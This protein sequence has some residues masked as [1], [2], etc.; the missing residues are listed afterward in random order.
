M[1]IPNDTSPEA[2]AVLREVY[3]RMPFERKWQQMGV[4]Y[5]TARILHAAGVR[6]RHPEAT[7]ER[8]QEAWR[9]ETLGEAAV[10]EIGKPR[11][12]SDNENLLVVQEVIAVLSRLNILYAL[13]GSWASSLLGKPRLTHDA[14]LSAEPFPGKEADFCSAFGEEYYISLSAVRDAVRQRSSFNII[15]F[16]SGFKVDVFVRKD[17]AFDQSVMTRRQPHSLGPDT[18]PP[19]MMVSAED[20]ILMKM[21]WF[22][23]GSEASERQWRDILGVW[24]TQGDRLD[25]AYLDH[26]AALLGV[27]DLLQ[28]ARQESSI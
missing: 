21:E 2:E 22:R 25:Q 18:G 16:P 6:A 19:V 11:M 7:P 27:A 17:R 9:M 3:R 20:I 13:G 15:H 4:L 14:A 28:R 24:A 12:T 8:I 5:Q 10:L 23:L 1:A 26:W